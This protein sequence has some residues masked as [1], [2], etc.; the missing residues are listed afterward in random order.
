MTRS[1]SWR[2]DWAGP[3]GTAWGTVNACLTTCTAAWLLHLA[4]GH[5]P[6]PI[7]PGRAV[8]AV[9][10][11]TAF[12]VLLV[13][14]RAAISKRQTPALTIAYK[15]CCWT[16]AGT[17]AGYMVA[18]ASWSWRWVLVRVGVL[19]ALALV[20]GVLAAAASDPPEPRT[21]EQKRE[22]RALRIRNGLAVE[23][24]QRLDSYTGR[25]G[26]HVP[27]VQHWPKGRGYTVEAHAPGGGVT[28]QAVARITEQLRGDLNLPSAG[29]IKVAAGRKARVAIIDV[30]TIDVL[31]QDYPYPADRKVHSINDPLAFGVRDDGTEI[32]PVLR[33]SCVSV[34]GETGSGKSNAGHDITAEIVTTDD[35][36]E[37][38]WDP[39]GKFW[40]A[41]LAPWL[42][43]EI[44]E[45]PVDWVASDEREIAFMARAGDRVGR[46]RPQAYS[47]LIINSDDDKL[48]VS[49][50][51]PALIIVGDE[52]APVLSVMSTHPAKDP[53]RAV[54]FEHRAGAVRT[55]YLP[56]RGTNDVIAESIQSQCH[57]RGVMR[58][59]SAAEAGWLGLQGFGPADT[60]Y[61]GCGGLILESGGPVHRLKWYRMTP[62]TIRA[63]SKLVQGRRPKLDEVSRL[64][65][66]GRN[67]DGTLMPN[68]LPGELDC[69]DTRW[70]R[71]RAGRPTSR[72]R[73]GTQAATTEPV[74]NVAH[75]VL[76]MQ[77][78]FADLD[79]T[80]EA[81]Q[82]DIEISD[83][84]RAEFDRLAAQLA[85]DGFDGEW[86]EPDGPETP[87]L[88]EHLEVLLA[89]LRDAG[90]RGAEPKVLRGQ[91]AAR[92][93]VKS[94]DTLHTWLAKLRDAGR[95]HQPAFGRWAAVEP[96]GR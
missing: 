30:T 24:E 91:L 28:S 1:A 71:Y 75:S 69:Y 38:V 17:W 52:V 65:A 77:A 21:A 9:V 18:H 67:P 12:G 87:E 25:P 19:V 43:G 60:P 58:V 54:T 27:A 7:P 83:E 44:A 68:L 33:Q 88:P 56:L 85:A 8:L 94:R 40:S 62:S 82:T 42:R 14:L 57:V 23:W 20:A 5:G 41:W 2:W 15:L 96:E 81:S 55:V 74:A 16:G 45:P 92:G 80:I 66:N 34:G 49:P 36:I 84:E 90:E 32:G 51:I 35:A 11:G 39:T 46:V 6:F 63:V 22:A 89:L 31:A 10:G 59:T 53:L 64:A 48:P 70:D 93:I 50:A 37:W 79:A 13:L 4:A 72:P 26:W 78:A 95:V 86:E 29:G 3:H 76:A 47:D 73:P 61:P